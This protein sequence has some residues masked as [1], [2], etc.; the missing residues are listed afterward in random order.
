[1]PDILANILLYD[2]FAIDRILGVDEQISSID[3][4]RNM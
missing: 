3:H 4:L 2:D 1:M